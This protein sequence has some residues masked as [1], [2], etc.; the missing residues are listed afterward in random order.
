LPDNAV[1]RDAVLAHLHELV[2]STDLPINADFENG[3]AHQP[4][5]LAENVR[6][7]V[8]TGVAGLSI[9]D[10]TGD[11]SNPLYDLDRAVARI[12]AAR[13]AIDQTG[14]DVILVGRAEC[15]LVG[16]S[17]IEEVKQRLKAYAEAGADCLYAPDLRTHE[18]VAAVVNAVAPKSVNVLISGP[19]SLTIQDVAGL[20][21]R[22]VSVGGALA[23]TAWGGFIKAAKELAEHGTFDGFEE[24]APHGEL[25]RFFSKYASG[26][27][28][29]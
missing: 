26:K 7:C 29:K 9:E 16:R 19:K 10:S 6:L 22:R 13:K 15:F 24:A 14:C 27:V 2:E 23:R 21:V 8:E 3:F 12:K 25:N 11:E 1:G 20:G 18:Q 28:T 17:D 4:N 5:D